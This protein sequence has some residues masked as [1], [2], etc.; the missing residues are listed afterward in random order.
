MQAV[1]RNF[2]FF[3]GT[4]ICKFTPIAKAPK[5]ASNLFHNIMAVS[6]KGN[7]KLKEQQKKDKPK[8]K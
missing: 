6:V 4:K 3:K 8:K 5:E 2:L 1:Y 7:P